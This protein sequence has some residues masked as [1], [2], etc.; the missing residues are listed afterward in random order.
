MGMRVS[1]VNPTEFQ[2]GSGQLTFI[3]FSQLI[4]SYKTTMYLLSQETLIPLAWKG[5]AGGII[6]LT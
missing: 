6:I 3:L 5:V 1:V 2:V 4:F